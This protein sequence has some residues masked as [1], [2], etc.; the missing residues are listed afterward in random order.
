MVFC[1]G[2]GGGA[3]G[4]GAGERLLVQPR[5]N[6]ILDVTNR[7]LFPGTQ[8]AEARTLAVEAPDF[9]RVPFYAEHVGGLLIG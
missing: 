8:L 5:E 3:V 4:A 1:V 6:V 9:Q 7:C 2:S